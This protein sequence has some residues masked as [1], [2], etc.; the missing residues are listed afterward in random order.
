MQKLKYW[1]ASAV[2]ALVAGVASAQSSVSVD[3]SA[4]EN[5]A[6]AIG[7]AMSGLINGKIMT[8]VL[9]V[10]GAGLAVYGVFLV[11]RYVRRGAR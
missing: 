2:P 9:L 11:V 3:V 6:D 10:I 8:N 7:T 1:V 5:A 4:A